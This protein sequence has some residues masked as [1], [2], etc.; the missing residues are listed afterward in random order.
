MVSWKLANQASVTRDFENVFKAS[1]LFPLFFSSSLP[2]SNHST[3]TALPKVYDE[4]QRFSALARHAEWRSEWSSDRH[5]QSYHDRAR[6]SDAFE[7]VPYYWVYCFS[8]TRSQLRFIH[9]CPYNPVLPTRMVWAHLLPF[10]NFNWW[11]HLK[12]SLG[13][14]MTH[15][16]RFNFNRTGSPV[17]SPFKPLS[18]LYVVR[19]L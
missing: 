16:M 15:G 6:T 2:S 3:C 8:Y 13:L 9:R 1:Q 11:G 19:F 4:Q 18:Q 17:T 14:L 5:C 12:A 10:A 7:Y